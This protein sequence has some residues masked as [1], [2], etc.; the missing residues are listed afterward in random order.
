MKLFRRMML[1]LFP[2]EMVNNPMNP[3][4]MFVGFISA[5]QYFSVIT[6][7]IVENYKLHL[8]DI[9]LDPFEVKIGFGESP[10]IKVKDVDFYY[11][12]A[13]AAN[14][15]GYRSFA[16]WQIAHAVALIA[17]TYCLDVS[18][19]YEQYYTTQYIYA[20][21]LLTFVFESRM[22]QF[23][24]GTQKEQF[25]WFIDVFFSF[26]EHVLSQTGKKVSPRIVSEI[27][28]HLLT[29]HI[30]LFFWLYYF[31]R[32]AGESLH[33][34]D[35]T[36]YHF[37]W[38]LF[39]DELKSG[40][41]QA[42]A[43]DFLEHCEKTVHQTSFTTTEKN[44]MPLLFPADLLIRYVLE[45]DNVPAVIRHLLM[46]FFPQEEVHTYMKSF[47]VNDE[48]FTDFLFFL[49]DYTS[50][51][52]AYFHWLKKYIT[53]IFQKKETYDWTDGA[54][55]D[56]WMSSIGEWGSIDMAKIPAR[57]REESEIMERLMNFYITYIGWYRIGRGDSRYIR[58]MHGTCLSAIQNT[59]ARQTIHDTMNYSQWLLANY[60]KNV[61]YYKY[62]FDN[63]RAGK[64]K[65][66][67]PFRATSKEV[68]SN[69][70][71]MKLFESSFVAIL[72]QDMLAK[73]IKIYTK[74]P[75][76]ISLFREHFG[77]H[78]S[79]L[80][81]KTNK[82]IVQQMYSVYDKLFPGT[83][84]SDT[85]R[86][87]HT[88]RDMT[89]LKESLY[90]LDYWLYTLTLEHIID[91]THT[92]LYT[93]YSYAHIAGIAAMMRETLCWFYLYYTYLCEHTPKKW[94][95]TIQSYPETFVVL[96]ESYIVDVLNADITL[97]PYFVRSFTHI[98]TTYKEILVTMIG[99]D[100]NAWYFYIAAENR[101]SYATGKTID[102][103]RAWCTG[104]DTIWFRG[105][106]KTITYYN[107]RYV[108]PQ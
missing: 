76:L 100:D 31:Y 70:C 4:S 81:K 41:F 28:Q 5:K 80:V 21:Y 17:S 22:K 27:K 36:D 30:E 102:E 106:L 10:T 34:H 19:K 8:F 88:K 52:N 63:I 45:G 89:A 105:F 94:D 54:E 96:F 66:H 51:K 53:H 64:E 40:D 93:T 12:Y 97:L 13:A 25:S 85:V 11:W 15:N 42:I 39:Y 9:S 33:I 79:R 38:R 98:Y 91:Q 3:A 90:T 26:Y 101:R 46:S 71:I 32:Y 56:E 43:Q 35:V 57:I 50:I 59:W 61:F 44:V 73:D 58:C 84:F 75:H 29:E 83:F 7:R 24:S 68:Y 82:S 78:V 92:F 18:E 20:V 65:F 107:K 69:N 95:A 23:P 48:L 60:S 6:R 2:D 62:A 37:F 87:S 104:E 1:S 99:I 108:L 49:S 14:L 16:P 77:T 103:I 74:N 47:L 67:L 86:A 72:L 55:V